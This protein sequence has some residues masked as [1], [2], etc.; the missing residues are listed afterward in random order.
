MKYPIPETRQYFAQ[1]IVEHALQAARL[2]TTGYYLSENG[3]LSR[4]K[5]EEL[6]WQIEQE[7]K[8][9]TRNAMKLLATQVTPTIEAKEEA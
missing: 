5:N 8:E 1:K 4:L 9:V 3:E 7:N 2:N 6:A